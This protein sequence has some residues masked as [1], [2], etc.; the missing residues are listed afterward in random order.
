MKKA[1]PPKYQEKALS[2]GKVIA[3]MA[4]VQLVSEENTLLLLCHH[5]EIYKTMDFSGE[6]QK[7]RE[8]E[9]FVSLQQLHEYPLWNIPVI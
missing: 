9:E 6:M 1:M 2:P 8:E 7:R 5:K 3:N 4:E